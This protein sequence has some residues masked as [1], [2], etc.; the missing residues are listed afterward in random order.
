MYLIEATRLALAQ[1]LVQKLKSFFTLLGVTIGVMFLIAVVSVVNGMS[2]YVEQDF[3]G[4]FLG[5]NTFYLRRFPG[6]RGNVTE[7]EWRLWQR[8]PKLALEDAYATRDALPPKFRWAI[9]DAIW[10]SPRTSLR[11]H[12]PQVRANSVTASYFRIKDLA[13]ERGRAFSEQE[14]AMGTPVAVIG[15]DVADDYFPNVN[16]IGRDVEIEHFP[17]RVVGVLERRGTVFG[18]SLD[19]QV[20]APFKSRMNRVT[21]A[22]DNLGV[23]IVQAPSDAAIAEGEEVTREVMRRRH[24]LPPGESDDFTLESSA[25]ALGRWLSVKSY[26]VVAGVVLPAI[27]LVVGA[28]VIMNIMLMSV[29]E[30]THE[31]GIRKALGARRR[32]ILAQFLIESTT[33]SV[34]GA[35]LGV[36]LGV[37]IAVGVSALTPL[38]AAVAAWSIVVSVSTGAAVGICAGVYPASR[39][40]QLD[41]VDALRAD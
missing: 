1:I 11:S 9:E 2:Q 15:Q 12:G 31:V 18:L 41:P 28:I 38:P 13:I 19:R 6:I 34:I 36:G 25:T 24:K 21:K 29:A 3:G 23:V 20:I 30:R 22:R 5:I 35:I 39:A 10:T 17:F 26:L 33:L 14:D 16:P 40:A 27:G 37:G 32:D 7:A 8:R 4:K